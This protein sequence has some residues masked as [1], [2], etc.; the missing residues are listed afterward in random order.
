MHPFLRRASNV[1]SLRIMDRPLVNIHV[2]RH[3]LRIC[4]ESYKLSDTHGL[5][6]NC[7]GRYYQ[8]KTRGEYVFLVLVKKARM[9]I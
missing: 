9:C 8:C 7:D 5:S 3:F 6:M 1:D 4:N 2:L